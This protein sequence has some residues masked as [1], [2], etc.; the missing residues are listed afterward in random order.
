[1]ET[2]QEL[3]DMLM[4]QPVIFSLIFGV[5]LNPA[6]S[7]LMILVSIRRCHIIWFTMNY[8]LYISNDFQREYFIFF[9]FR[10]RV[11][12]NCSLNSFDITSGYL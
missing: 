9:F 4:D 11:G 6:L 8:T 7:G 5:F 2:V 10:S 12:F 3:T 1:M